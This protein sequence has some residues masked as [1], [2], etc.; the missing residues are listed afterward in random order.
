MYGLWAVLIRVCTLVLAKDMGSL[1]QQ[2]IQSR[3]C[4]LKKENSLDASPWSLIF[5][6]AIPVVEFSRKGYKIRK[7]FGCISKIN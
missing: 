1:V 2:L 7:I 3:H 6:M 5:I 4:H